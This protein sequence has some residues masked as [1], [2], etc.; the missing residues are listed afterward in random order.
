MT[1]KRKRGHK[2][3][4]PIVKDDEMIVQLVKEILEIEGFQVD[5]I[6]S[7][8]DIPQTICIR[9]S[10]ISRQKENMN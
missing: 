8:C 6:T 5:V 3:E 10:K 9:Y 1:E 4:A 7:D 2:K